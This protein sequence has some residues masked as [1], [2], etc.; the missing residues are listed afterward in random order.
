MSGKEIWDFQTTKE[1]SDQVESG[2]YPKLTDEE[3]VWEEVNILKHIHAGWFTEDILKEL[4][5][6]WQKDYIHFRKLNSLGLIKTKE[7]SMPSA[8]KDFEV[9]F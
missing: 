4:N 8:F 6:S 7:H 9:H 5:M 3:T 2:A 1:G